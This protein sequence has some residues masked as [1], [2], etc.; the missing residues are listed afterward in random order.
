[1]RSARDGEKRSV[2]PWPLAG[3]GALRAGLCRRLFE[4]ILI[5]AAVSRQREFLADVAQSHA[6]KSRDGIAR[7]VREDE[8]HSPVPASVLPRPRRPATSSSATRWA[9]S[10]DCRNHP[11][12]GIRR[13]DP[14]FDSRLSKVHLTTAEPSPEARSRRSLGP[15]PH[16]EGASPRST[17]RTSSE[18]RR[19][20]GTQAAVLTSL[21][22]PLRYLAY[23]PFG[24]RAIV[25]ALLV[26]HENETRQGAAIGLAG[27]QNRRFLQ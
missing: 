26:D 2:N 7:T 13:I 21:P 11:P 1:M 14:S 18:S 8:P 10:W 23:D 4:Q 17:P 20:G 19:H 9:G 5:K 15:P 6:V 16:R 25:F 27:T 12:S 24:A 3:L 22:D